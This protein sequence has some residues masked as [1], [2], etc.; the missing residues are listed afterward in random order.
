MCFEQDLA[1]FRKEKHKSTPLHGLVLFSAINGVFLVFAVSP[2]I[3]RNS[4]QLE[5]NGVLSNHFFLNVENYKKN[6][7]FMV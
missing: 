4:I 5:K 1:P 6:A 7:K 3:L 2:S